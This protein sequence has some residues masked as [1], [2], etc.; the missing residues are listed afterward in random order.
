MKYFPTLLTV[1]VLF[2]QSFNCFAEKHEVKIIATVNQTP[3]TN[4]DV[5]KRQE[6]LQAFIPEFGKFAPEQK[7]MYAVQ[8][9]IQDEL[10]KDYIKRMGIKITDADLKTKTTE[11]VAILKKAK[12]GDINSFMQKHQ[13]FAE[14]EI[15]WSVVVANQIKPSITVSNK[16]VEEIQKENQQMTKDQITESITM[17]QV[18]IQ[19]NQILESLRKISVIEINL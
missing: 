5:Q 9:L 16:M 17:Q 18:E 4:V 14:T 6:I 3:I 15:S 1:S 10:K 13:D 2:L 12:I 11:F 7:L 8:N 19:T